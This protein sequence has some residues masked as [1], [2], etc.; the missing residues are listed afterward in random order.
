MIHEFDPAK[1]DAIEAAVRIQTMEKIASME[2]GASA[3]AARAATPSLE[4]VTLNQCIELLPADH[5]DRARDV[6]E[7][8][9]VTYG[10]GA[11]E[12][13]ACL[14]RV[15]I[16]KPETSDIDGVKSVCA[17]G[18]EKGRFESSISRS[19]RMIRSRCLQLNCDRMLTLTK[20][21]KFSSVDEC[22]RAFK[23]FSRLM[24]V[25]FGERWRYVCVPELHADGETYHMHV[26]IRGFYMVESVRALWFRALGGRGNERGEKTPGNVDIKSFTGRWFG[27]AGGSRVRRIAGYI[28][29]YVGKGFGACN[30]GRRLFSASRGLHPDRVERWRVRDWVGVPELA[31]AL[32]KQ[33]ASVGG[34]EVGDCYLWSRHRPDGSLLMC[35]FI[36]STEMR[37]GKCH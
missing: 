1:V 30:R 24:E 28:A 9:R 12:I 3:R 5:S 18:S 11:V 37:A 14:G 2:S 10:S 23:E 8:S 13:R 32:Q 15:S 20:R 16:R 35:G 31:V 7:V 4:E 29:K 34:V 22:W 27:R 33:F 6:W 36:L 17:G 21:G 25:R 26:G 19:R